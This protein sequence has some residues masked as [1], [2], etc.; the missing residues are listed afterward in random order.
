M[1]NCSVSI[2]NKQFFVNFS[3]LQ[4]ALSFCADSVVVIFLV[5]FL[6]F[7]QILRKDSIVLQRLQ[8]HSKCRVN[9]KAHDTCYFPK[10]SLFDFHFINT[11]FQTGLCCCKMRQ[12]QR[13]DNQKLKGIFIRFCHMLFYFCF[14]RIEH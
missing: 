6:R 13:C 9:R 5:N 8:M 4:F 3:K 10:R 2:I 14:I 7:S 1:I 11:F 12:A